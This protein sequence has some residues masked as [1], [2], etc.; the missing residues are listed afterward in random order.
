M[1]KTLTIKTEDGKE[2]LCDI[3]F[4]YHSPEF[5]KDYIV[6]TSKADGITSAAIYNSKGNGEGE[7][8]EIK[9]E[10]EWKMLEELLE[11]YSNKKEECDND[12][13]SCS[14]CEGCAS[15]NKDSE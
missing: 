1:D 5:N 10:E 15:C 8:V 12:C 2:I 6:F 11:D 4:T 9:S 3:L 13:S 7:L 14:Q